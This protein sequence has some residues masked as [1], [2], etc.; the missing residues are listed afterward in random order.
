MLDEGRR[1]QEISSGKIGIIQAEVHKHYSALDA[2]LIENLSPV[3]KSKWEPYY[4]VKFTPNNIR[5]VVKSNL[6]P[7][8]QYASSK[9]PA[10][11]IQMTNG[12]Q[13]APHQK[14][15]LLRKYGKGTNGH[16]RFHLALDFFTMSNDDFFQL[17]GFN[18]VPKGQLFDDAKEFLHHYGQTELL[19]ETKAQV[20]IHMDTT[21]LLEGSTY[22]HTEKSGKNHNG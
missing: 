13:E 4:L 15:R 12:K 22:A 3:E 11:P 21:S 7:I 19:A 17:Y 1:V 16:D 9:P 20:H 8:H 14:E 10:E 18:F 5:L 6:R 2:A